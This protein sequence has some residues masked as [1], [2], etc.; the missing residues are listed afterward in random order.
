MEDLIKKYEIHAEVLLK[1]LQDKDSTE[2]EMKIYAASRR[3]VVSFIYD[4]N[5]LN[6][7]NDEL[8]E[9]SEIFGTVVVLE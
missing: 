1:L 9:L 2:E 4:L 7:S 8:Y 5:A 6:N 3:F